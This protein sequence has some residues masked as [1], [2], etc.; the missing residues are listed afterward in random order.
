M[1]SVTTHDIPPTLGYLRDEHIRLRDEL[2]LLTEDP[3]NLYR[4]A[5]EDR[6]HVVKQLQQSHLLSTSWTD[7]DISIGLQRSLFKT[8]SQLICFSMADFVGE[9]RAQNQPGTSE[10]YP[11]W[12]TE[13]KDI[14]GNLVYNEDYFE[15]PFFKHFYGKIPE[16]QEIG[17]K[18]GS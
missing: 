18:D 17:E 5:R 12:R 13:L 1:T 11:N 15:N 9:T 6:E 2:G 10:E 14:D 16:F 4:E 7:V 8:P 3:E